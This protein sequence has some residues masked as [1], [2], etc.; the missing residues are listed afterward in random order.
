MASVTESVLGQIEPPKDSHG[1]IYWVICVIGGGGVAVIGK[2][3]RMIKAA[4]EE[5]IASLE[6]Q[7]K[8]LQA[9]SAECVK[10]RESLGIRVARL[11]ATLTEDE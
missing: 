11:E 10:E 2:L 5:R 6:E 8:E 9:A 7:T 3:A 4:D 1:W